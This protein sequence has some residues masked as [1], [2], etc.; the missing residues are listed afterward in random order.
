M[1]TEQKVQV[2]RDRESHH[3]EGSDYRSDCFIGRGVR[4]SKRLGEH[5]FSNGDGQV[6]SELYV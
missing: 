4:T 6:S 2:L 1:E 5:S 3:A